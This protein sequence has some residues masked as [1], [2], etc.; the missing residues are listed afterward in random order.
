MPTRHEFG[1]PWT[2]DKLGRVQRYLVEYRKIFSKNPR[3]KYFRTVYVDAFAGTGYRTDSM[4]NP[5]PDLWSG[6]RDDPD[7]ASLLKGSAYNALEV[8]PPF[9]EYFFVER[10]ADRARDLEALRL[11]FPDRAANVTIVNQDANAFLHDW[12]RR[13]DWRT[14][15]AVVFLDPY[16]LQVDWT[17]IEAIA[18]TKS[19]DLWYLFPL[20]IGVNRL[21][22]HEPPPPKWADAI[23]RILGTN[24]WEDAFYRNTS[25]LSLF[26]EPGHDQKVADFGSIS[27]FFVD[28]LKAIFAA[29][30][31]NPL[32]LYNSKGVPLYLLC[33]AAANPRGAPTAISIAKYILEMDD[34]KFHQDR[35]D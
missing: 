16:G 15:R 10:N 1:G 6:D 5:M 24:T 11:Q 23:T 18:E 20:G 29:V 19:I 32:A 2:E 14:K 4:H 33:F 25:Q 7:K 12:C 31:E 3:A 34:G 26:D 8:N 28:R 30:A 22:T 27:R 21:L 9:D 17:T 35:V 13:T